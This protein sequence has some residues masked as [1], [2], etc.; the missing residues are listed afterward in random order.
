MKNALPEQLQPRFEQYHQTKD[1]NDIDLTAVVRTILVEAGLLQYVIAAYDNDRFILE[2][3]NKPSE[4]QR[5]LLNRYWSFQL[6][7]S[8]KSSI[9]ERSY[10]I[11]NGEIEDWIR[12]F[13]NK[14]L[15]FI[16]ENNLPTP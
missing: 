9:E 11:P 16:L 2:A 14:V 12:L 5:F 13:Q 15:P 10:L 6:M 4:V 1:A 3:Q 8:E 7:Q